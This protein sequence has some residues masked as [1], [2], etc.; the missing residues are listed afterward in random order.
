MNAV[1]S[2]SDD[3]GAGSFI[4]TKYEDLVIQPEVEMRRICRE[5]ELEFD[6]VMLDVAMRKKDPV[7]TSDAGYPHK[8]L[9]VAIDPS[10]ANTGE[11]LPGWACYIVEKYAKR[12]LVDQGYSLR[13]PSI[14][15]VT[16]LKISAVL[17]KLKLRTN[18]KEAANL[19]WQ[20]K[21]RLITD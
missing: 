13:R 5:L 9:A 3:F 20:S 12:A 6:M 1:N 18:L 15:A 11:E 17:S 7:V 10:R 2:A 16:R 19:N 14:S 21:F 4:T 8:R